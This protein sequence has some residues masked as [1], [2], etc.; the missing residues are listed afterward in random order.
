MSTICFLYRIKENPI[1]YY[2]KYVTNYL[3]ENHKGLDKEILPTFL[4]LYNQYRKKERESDLGE[5]D[6]HLGVI[7]FSTHTN[8]MDYCSSQEISFFDFYYEEYYDTKTYGRFCF[9]HGEKVEC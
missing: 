9:V 2:G 6:I 4:S 5:Q 1:V 7:S 3:Q 8:S